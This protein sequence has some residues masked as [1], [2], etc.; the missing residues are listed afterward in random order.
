MIEQELTKKDMLWYTDKLVCIYTSGT[1]QLHIVHLQYCIK[2]VYE[3]ICF[4]RDVYKCAMER[5]KKPVCCIC[6]SR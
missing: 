5:I 6:L 2:Y 3:S 1:M 4:L